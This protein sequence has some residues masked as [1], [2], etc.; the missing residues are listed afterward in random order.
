MTEEF[1]PEDAQILEIV[2]ENEDKDSGY[3]V[4]PRPYREE[5]VPAAKKNWMDDYGDQVIPRGRGFITDFVYHTRG[6]MTP[7]LAC[8]WSSLW[9]LSTAIKR[10]AWL[11]WMPAALFPNIFMVII[12]PA[13]RA[14]KTTAV[15]QIGLPILR[16][17]REFIRDKNIYQM[18]YIN[19]V[20]DMNSPEYVIDS[21]LPERKPGEDFYLVDRK[22]ENIRD[23]KGN[24]VVYR[25]TSETALVTSELSTFLST[26]SYAESMTSLML[27]LYDAHTDWEWNTLGKGKKTLRRMFTTFAAGTTIDGLRGSIPKAAKGDGFLSRT[28]LVYVPSSKR[29]YDMPREAYGCP[30]TDEMSRRLAWVAEHTIGEFTLSPEA[31]EEYSKWYKWFYKK[32]ED[33][34]AIEG[35]ISRMDVHLLK[36]ALLIRASRYDALGLQIEMEDLQDAI[37]LIDATYASFPLLLSQLDEDTVIQAVSKV[38]LLLQRHKELS[39]QKVLVYSRLRTDALHLVFQELAARGCVEFVINDKVQ[40]FSSGRPEEMV[41]WI[42]GDD[43]TNSDSGS[44]GERADF[45]YAQESRGDPAM[46]SAARRQSHGLEAVAQ[47]SGFEEPSP[48]KTRKPRT[49]DK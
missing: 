16:K 8:I 6:Y 13:G 39:R 12:G 2:K 37:R 27:D 40:T 44:S 19:I 15:T 23:S 33:N 45:C 17:F 43:G 46:R 32:M 5:K 1:D 29:Q 24:V 10:E 30:D 28:V 25:K 20:K 48:G 38:E 22:G 3:I 4:P 9:L 11:K 41:R 31:R 21:M 49:L 47:Q 42:G 18:K 7:T 14:K 34:P 35:A 26:R 36:T